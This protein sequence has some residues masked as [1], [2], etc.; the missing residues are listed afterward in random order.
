MVTWSPGEHNCTAMY[1]GPVR[2]ILPGMGAPFLLKV[3]LSP[4]TCTSTTSPVT[5]LLLTAPGTIIRKSQRPSTNTLNR[6]DIRVLF[7]MCDQSAAT[8]HGS[9]R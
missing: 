9:C 5:R 3:T 8:F 7:S 4:R 6:R 1:T 2:R